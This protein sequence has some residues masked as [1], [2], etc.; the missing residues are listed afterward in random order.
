MHRHTHTHTR[1]HAR[2]QCVSHTHTH[3]HAHSVSHTHT[4]AHIHPPTPP[5]P[6]THTKTATPTQAQPHIHTHTHTHTHTHK[7]RRNAAA[8]TCKSNNRTPPSKLPVA[9]NGPTPGA[10]GP[11]H[12]LVTGPACPYETGDTAKLPQAT[13]H[14]NTQC[15]AHSA[16]TIQHKNEKRMRAPLHTHTHSAVKTHKLRNACMLEKVLAGKDRS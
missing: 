8:F 1:T 5:P 6:P 13:L 2:T 15:S 9:T 14:T 4:R 11:Q 12:R 3:T 16:A 10:P 7:Q